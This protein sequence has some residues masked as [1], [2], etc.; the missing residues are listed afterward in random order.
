MDQ[1]NRLKTM[2]KENG[3]MKRPVA[4]LPLDNHQILREASSGNFKPRQRG[5]GP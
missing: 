1:A 4:D 2:E 3:Q 5:G